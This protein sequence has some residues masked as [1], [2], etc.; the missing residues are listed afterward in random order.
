[1]IHSIPDLLQDIRQGKMVIWVDSTHRENEGDIMVA[2]EYATPEVINFMMTYARGLVCMPL[3]A[4]K[5]AELEL[6]PMVEKNNAHFGTDFTVSVDAAYGITTGV[7][8]FDKAATVKVIL[9]KEAKPSDLVRPGHLFP[10]MVKN[11]GVL[12][13]PG[14]TEACHDAAWL[15]GL[16]PCAVLAEILNPDGSMARGKDLVHFANTHALKIGTVADLIV[17]RQQHCHV[18]EGWH[19]EVYS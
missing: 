13:R 15:A 14:H 4:Q 2:A 9:N 8:A 1:M 6:P 18:S 19:S 12:A 3:S 11:G 7:S 10:L 5:C 16:E 17:Y